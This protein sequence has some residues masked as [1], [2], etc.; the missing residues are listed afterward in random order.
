[1]KLCL[2]NRKGVTSCPSVSSPKGSGSNENRTNGY[3][4][5]F[6]GMNYA[7]KRRPVSAGRNAFCQTESLGIF[8]CEAYK[9]ATVAHPAAL[10][11]KNRPS[12]RNFFVMEN[13][14]KPCSVAKEED[15]ADVPPCLYQSRRRA[16]VLHVLGLHHGRRPCV[17]LPITVKMIP[18]P[19]RLGK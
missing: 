9:I 17:I 1:M 15:Y 16:G 5:S 3:P 6:D 10:G 8:W 11:S 19:S 4:L 14:G 12:R 18:L 7:G 13:V 2:T